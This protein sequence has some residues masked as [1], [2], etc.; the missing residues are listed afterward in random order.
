VT[1]HLA[2]CRATLERDPAHPAH[3]PVAVA[4]AGDSLW[5]RLPEH[6]RPGVHPPADA[7]H[8]AALDDLLRERAETWL[9]GHTL[10]FETAWL[11]VAVPRFVERLDQQRAA[12]GRLS[13][14]LALPLDYLGVG[15]DWSAGLW[16]RDA[17][18]QLQSW[19]DRAEANP[20]LRKLA[21]TLGRLEDAATTARAARSAAPRV[22][23]G[24][25]SEVV[26]VGLG[27]DLELALAQERALLA[28]P[29]LE[30][31]FWPRYLESRLQQLELDGEALQHDLAQN[32]VGLGTAA[33]AVVVCLDTS[34]SMRGIPEHVAKALTLAVLKV[35]LR[36]KR[37]CHLVAFA[38]SRDLEILDLTHLEL[39]PLLELLSGRFGGGT[40]PGAALDAALD[41]D[42]TGADVLLVTDG[43]F[44]LSPGL[45]A[46]LDRAGE[47]G[48]RVHVLLTG[49]RAPPFD[50]H[51]TWRWTGTVGQGEAQLV[52]GLSPSS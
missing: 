4:L 50:A 28:D 7:E 12:I 30:W 13:Q 33:G 14:V 3:G 48:A 42:L 29:E 26:G 49:D 45:S 22:A 6:L 34:G 8:A 43:A 16:R 10:D 23:S 35:A 41:R 52:Q 27:R 31:L 11:N 18:D 5:E 9:L 51:R 39:G 46:A 20:S 44:V 19:S 36:S 2:L 32:P 38:A 47:S 25:R 37:A 24:G 17:W 21:E 1:E 40:D 15:G